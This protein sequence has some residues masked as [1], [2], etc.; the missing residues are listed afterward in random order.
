MVVGQLE[1]TMKC[2]RIAPNYSL[3]WVVAVYIL[4]TVNGSSCFP[5]PFTA[6]SRETWV[7]FFPIPRCGPQPADGHTCPQVCPCSC[8]RPPA[9]PWQLWSQCSV[10]SPRSS[11]CKYFEHISFRPFFFF[12]L[13]HKIISGPVYA[14]LSFFPFLP[15]QRKPLIWSWCIFF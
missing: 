3:K 5:P 8:C 13:R 15:A 1:R 9:G 12:L 2:E 10:E 4:I 6:L 11:C 14:F 7:P